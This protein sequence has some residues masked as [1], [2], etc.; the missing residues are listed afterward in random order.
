MSSNYLIQEINTLYEIFRSEKVFLLYFDP[1]E[2]TL[3]NPE[4]ARR[5]GIGL[6]KRFNL[7]QYRDR[8]V[9]CRDFYGDPDP[10]GHLGFFPILIFDSTQLG[11]TNKIGRELIKFIEFRNVYIYNGIKKENFI[12]VPT[13]RHFYLENGDIRLRTM[14]FGRQYNFEIIL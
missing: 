9:V 1:N 11:V 5:R 7:Q 12:L 3:N 6:L 14:T 2:I 13:G 10:M 8:L 4:V